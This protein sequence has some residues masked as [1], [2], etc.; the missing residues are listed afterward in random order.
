MEELFGNLEIAQFSFLKDKSKI[1]FDANKYFELLLAN[2]GHL[3]F[4]TK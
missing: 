2:I 3:T 1:N 4:F